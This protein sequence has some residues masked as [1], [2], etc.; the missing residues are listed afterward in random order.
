MNVSEESYFWAAKKVTNNKHTELESFVELVGGV[1]SGEGALAPTARIAERS[2]E[3]AAAV[4]RMAD[5]DDGSM[6]PL[7]KSEVVK[8]VM[9]EGG[10]VQMKA[11]LGA[12]AEPEMPLFPGG[13]VTSPD[14]MK[15]LPYH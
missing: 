9:Q 2:G 1:S 13:L 4:D 3:F 14:G 5:S 8:Q 11:V 12:D 10:Q 6:V 15:W 7:F